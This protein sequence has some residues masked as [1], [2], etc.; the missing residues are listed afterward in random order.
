MKIIHV[1]TALEMGGAESM[2]HRLLASMDQSRYES[3]VVSL[4]PPGPMVAPIEALGIP[5]R[6]LGVRHPGSVPLAIARLTQLLWQERPDLLQT[7]MYHADLVGGLAGRLAGQVPTVWNI[8]H[9]KLE[10][11][12]HKR[13]TM[14]T[15]TACARLS[16]HLPVRIISCSRAAMALHAER[17]YDRG[18][19]VVIPN[20]FDMAAFRPDPAARRF[21]RQEL[22][23]PEDS[24][25]IGLAARFD[26]QKDHRSF[27]QAA[28]RLHAAIP[29]VHFVL[30]GDEMTWE[31][32]EVASWVGEARLREHCHLLGRRHDMQRLQA[33]FDI[34]TLSS[35]SGEGFPNVLGEAMACGVPCVS[36]DVGDAAWI[37]GNT[38]CIVPPRDPVALAAAW[39]QLLRQPAAER[40]ALGHAARTRIREHFALPAIVSAYERLYDDVVQS[41]ARHP[42]R[43]ALALDKKR[44]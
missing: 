12:A 44:A 31:N 23:L 28:A 16:W 43:P 15:A 9:G 3:S 10:P 17:G 4:G 38:G 25:L 8:R 19:M 32:P 42:R 2:L 11:G 36:T 6:S 5:V 37:V 41:V 30:C 33:S 21:V 1:I 20:G 27:F 24:L 18:R 40:V 39:S 14:L 35:R 34:A 13:S 22:G 7:W 29:G 26:P